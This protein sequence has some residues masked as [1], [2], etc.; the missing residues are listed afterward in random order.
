MEEVIYDVLEYNGSGQPNI[1]VFMT[2]I[3]KNG[4]KA[5]FSASDCLAVPNIEMS[6]PLVC[7]YNVTELPH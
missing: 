5:R 3:L 1:E 2:V 4:N 7:S 6:A